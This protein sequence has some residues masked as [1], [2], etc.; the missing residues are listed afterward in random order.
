MTGG[1]AIAKLQPD[2]SP[3]ACRPGGG[4]GGEGIQAVCRAR[5]EREVQQFTRLRQLSFFSY[6]I[7]RKCFGRWRQVCPVRRSISESLGHIA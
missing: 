3:T 2:N 4:T 6:F 1:A 7:S 5:R